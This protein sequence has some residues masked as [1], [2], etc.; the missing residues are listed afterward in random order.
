MN[1]GQTRR[2]RPPKWPRIKRFG[3]GYMVD[4]GRAFKPRR[5]LIL[6]TMNDAFAKAEEWRAERKAAEEAKRFESENRAVSLAGLTDP[7]RRDVLAALEALAGRGTLAGAVD[8]YMRHAAPA[9]PRT[10]AEVTGGIAAGV[11]AYHVDEASFA[12]GLAFFRRDQ[13]AEARSAFARADPAQRDPRTQFY[14]AYSYYREGWGR[15]YSD[16][17]LFSKG[18]EAA[19]RAVEVSPNGHVEVSDPD[20]KMSTSDELVAE[21]QRGLTRDVSDLNPLRLLEERK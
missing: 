3:T 11:G 13:F 12:A 6:A 18:L 5:R 9:N 14:I 19:R 15:T 2:G 16:D 1:D 10:V 20:L 8:F 7:Q 17:A 4:S 21:L